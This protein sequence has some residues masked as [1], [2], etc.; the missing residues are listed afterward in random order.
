MIVEKLTKL[1]ESTYEVAID[2]KNYV[3][4]EEMVLKYRL[5]KGYEISEGELKSCLAEHDFEMIKKKAY[6]Y[7]LKYQKNGYE[8]LHYL[9]D[10]EIPFEMAKN[11]C[12]WLLEHHKIDEAMLA[13]GVAGA[14]AR[15]SNGA[16]MIRYKL[17]NRHFLEENITLA[18]ETLEDADIVLGKEKLIQRVEKRYKGLTKKEQEQKIKE[19]LYRHGYYEG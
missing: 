11:A 16:L 13:K 4:D 10:K 3:L 2:K 7:Y 9:L 12:D 5:F 6:H 17:K 14:L 18:L 15:S 19:T 8:V 1:K